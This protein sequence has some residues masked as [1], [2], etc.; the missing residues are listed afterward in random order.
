M[1]ENK[2]CLTNKSAKVNKLLTAQQKSF[3]EYLSN[4]WLQGF[5]SFLQSIFVNLTFNHNKAVKIHKPY[6]LLLGLALQKLLILQKAD[7]V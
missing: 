2:G 1:L 7:K 4:K 6:S 5:V 3:L